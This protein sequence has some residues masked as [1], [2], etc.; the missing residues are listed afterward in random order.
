MPT[1][2]TS[3]ATNLKVIKEVTYHELMSNGKLGPPLIN[4]HSPVDI[5]LSI[6]QLQ[7]VLVF[8]M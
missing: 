5:L 8:D 6:I 1:L 7:Q 3:S 2:E 4:D